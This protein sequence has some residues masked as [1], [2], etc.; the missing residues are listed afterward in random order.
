M[1]VCNA[2]L[3][4][5]LDPVITVTLTLIDHAGPLVVS[6]KGVWETI[7][8]LDIV[9]GTRATDY[10]VQLKALLQYCPS[11]IMLRGDNGCLFA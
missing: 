8:R 5:N 3:V 6:V 7:R 1:S 11:V 4:L 10:R 9:E 2:R